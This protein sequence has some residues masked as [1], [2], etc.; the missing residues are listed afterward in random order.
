MCFRRWAADNLMTHIT[1]K[2]TGE[3]WGRV[4]LGHADFDFEGG[5]VREFLPAVTN[6]YN[7]AD[8]LLNSD[9]VSIRPTSRLVVNGRFH[10]L[11][12]G[13]DAPICAGD[14]VTLMSASRPP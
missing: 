3:F 11:V 10:Y 1:L 9:Q 14:V 12:G 6:A 8:L 5:A 2:F 7:V 4:G 13:L